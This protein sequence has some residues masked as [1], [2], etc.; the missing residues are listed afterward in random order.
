[1]PKNAPC[2][3]VMFL[4]GGIESMGIIYLI[5]NSADGFN[6]GLSEYGRTMYPYSNWFGKT[7]VRSNFYSILLMWRRMRTLEF[8]I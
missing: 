5:N 1:M 2:P 4:G 8:L 7:Y 3:L 6:Y